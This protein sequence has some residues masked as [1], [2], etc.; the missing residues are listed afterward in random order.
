MSF[1]SKQILLTASDLYL[2][3]GNRDILSGVSFSIYEGEKVALVGRNG[4]GKTSI[5]RIL[6]GDEKEDAGRVE[7]RRDLTVGYLPQ[8]FLLHNEKNVYENIRL[9]ARDLISLLAQYE[10]DK[11]S[12]ERKHEL[13]DEISHLDGWNLHNHVESLINTMK[14]PPKEKHI[15]DLSGGEKRRVALA[16]AIVANPDLLIL[17]EPTNHLDTENIEWLENFLEK[18]KGACLFITHDRYFLDR[19]ATRI[20][21]LSNGKLFSHSGNYTEFLIK[22]AEREEAEERSEHNRQKFLNKELE[23]IARSPQGRTTKSKGRIQRYYEAAGKEFKGA[24]IDVDLIIPNPPG[25]SDRVLDLKK[26]GHDIHGKTLFSDINIQFAKGMRVGVVGR[27][28]AGKSTLLKVI[29]KQLEPT[30]GTVDIAAR[31]EINFADQEKLFLH[32]DKTVISEISDS[33]DTVNIGGKTIHPKGY[34][35]RFLFNEN[36]I[37]SLVKNLS[38]GERSRLILA[39]ILKSGGNFLILDEPTNDLD[40]STLRILEEAL[41]TFDGCVLVVSH[42]RYFLN[43]VCTHILGLEE[44]GKTRFI[45]GDYDLYKKMK[46]EYSVGSTQYK[47]D[48][49]RGEDAIFNMQDTIKD[50]KKIDF[51]KQREISKL[52]RQIEHAEAE[53]KKREAIFH[54]E[55]F[56]QKFGDK[57]VVLAEDLQKAK[58]KVTELYKKWEK[59]VGGS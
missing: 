52:E 6:V 15:K 42:D 54:N 44:N 58:D 56:Y 3:I 10:N 41:I 50:E 59:M 35:K 19:I 24:D 22:K 31:T 33:F 34:L 46:G 57:I 7:K 23:W 20:L 28:G 8:E 43:R 14:L 18:Y 21:E 29:T 11:T 47:V 39:K 37:N 55:D 25:L 4:S 9:G 1:S 36:Q 45:G 26:V 51:V 48:E 5:L 17:D 16:A 12:P 49:G 30:R 38:G 13:Y 2:H 53:V 40:L 27:N 32:P